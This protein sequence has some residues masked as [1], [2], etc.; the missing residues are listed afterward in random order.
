MAKANN[1]AIEGR[2]IKFRCW[3]GKTMMYQ[4]DYE[5]A[6]AHW[7]ISSIFEYNDGA[8]F[9]QYT[10][11]KDKAGTE[12]YEGDIVSIEHRTQGSGKYTKYKQFNCPVEYY[13]AGFI[14]KWPEDYGAYR[15]RDGDNFT[16]SEVIGN[17]YQHPQLI[18]NQSLTK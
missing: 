1:T 2:E 9:M 4:D 3:D 15:F 17:I 18:S 7:N 11:L 13:K 8:T 6:S 5:E 10:G 12:I 14:V 16:K